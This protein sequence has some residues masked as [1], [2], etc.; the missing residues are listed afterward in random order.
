MRGFFRFLWL[1]PV[2][3]VVGGAISWAAHVVGPSPGD[4]R[5]AGQPVE[6]DQDAIPTEDEIQRELEF[7]AT[8]PG[9]GCERIL[10]AVEMANMGHAGIVDGWDRLMA[11]AAARAKMHG[12][13]IN[14]PALLATVSRD[15]T[16]SIAKGQ[17]LLWLAASKAGAVNADLESIVRMY[18]ECLEAIGSADSPSARE[19]RISALN[20]KANTLSRLKRPDQAVAVHAEAME[21]N[22]LATG[23][24]SEG[25][26]RLMQNHARL[27]REAGDP[28][29][30][31]DLYDRILLVKPRTRREIDEYLLNAIRRYQVGMQTDDPH[32]GIVALEAA[33]ADP[34]LR[35]TH[36]IVEVG[37]ELANARGRIAGM[38][39][40][41]C[42]LAVEI[43]GLINARRSE[44]IESSRGVLTFK[45][46][47]VQVREIQISCASLLQSYVLHG[48]REYLDLAY[49]TLLDTETDPAEQET[50]VRNWARAIRSLEEYLASK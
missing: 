32:G 26:R 31:C 17:G 10:K 24:N 33:W 11:E 40:S 15:S 48:S 9:L 14:V 37:W 36:E 28:K 42:D 23:G 44:W 29:A 35:V 47:E 2:A 16:D 34:A 27:L 43:I 39:R 45:P 13:E 4:H 1:V 22:R 30:A 7:L 19:I 49:Q 3:V 6:I 50:T 21:I 12:C 46:V 18:D 38:S 41:R 25:D 8:S 5:R 20:R